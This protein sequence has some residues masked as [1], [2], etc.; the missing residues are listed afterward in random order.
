MKKF[1]LFICL[2]FICNSAMASDIPYINSI[3]YV[4]YK[5]EIK[6]NKIHT[7][8]MVENEIYVIK[9][10]YKFNSL[11]SQLG[12]PY[13]YIIKNNSN[14]TLYLKGCITKKDFWNRDLNKKHG[15]RWANM[16][17][18]TLRNNK[19]YIPVYGSVIGYDADKEKNA[20]IRDLPK[21]KELK[22][23]DSIRIL[24]LGS[25]LDNIQNMRFIFVDDGN[26]FSIEF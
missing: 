2:M 11:A 13:E 24:A 19:S 3:P 23:G 20:F 8:S 16:A 21:N 17:K 6:L 9:N 26:E 15:K 25:L 1:L 5:D 7:Y 18:A 4:E 22:T 14:K 10:V 12:L